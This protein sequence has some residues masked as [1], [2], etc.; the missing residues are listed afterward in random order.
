[1]FRRKQSIYSQLTS[2]SLLVAL[3]C[4]NGSEVHADKQPSL[5]TGTSENYFNLG[6]EEAYVAWEHWHNRVGKVM[7]KR[8]NHAAGKN[9]GIISLHVTVKKDHSLTAELTSCTNEKI[10]DICLDS[11]KSLD[12]DPVLEFPPESKR[13]EISFDL[14]FKKALFTLPKNTFI[15]D[16][17][18]HVNAEEQK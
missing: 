4:F 18:E 6:S 13:T 5:K 15:K 16:D 1:M 8:I 10:R 12:G 7:A 17:Y 2:V 14:S 3:A 9:L 11:I